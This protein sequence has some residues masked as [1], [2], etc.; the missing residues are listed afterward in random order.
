MSSNVRRWHFAAPRLPSFPFHTRPNEEGKGRYV[1][2]KLR[3]EEKKTVRQVVKRAQFRREEGD[4]ALTRLTVWNDVDH[5]QRAACR[6]HLHHHAYR[7]VTDHSYKCYGVIV[8]GLH[9]LSIPHN[10]TSF[11]GLQLN[12]YHDSVEHI[13]RATTAERTLYGFQR[14][15]RSTNMRLGRVPFSRPVKSGPGLPSVHSYLLP[16]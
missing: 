1:R 5:S 13:V 2:R 16:N 9:P 14:L 8:N 12:P 10:V 11:L 15:F 4:P 3:E 6:A 7:P